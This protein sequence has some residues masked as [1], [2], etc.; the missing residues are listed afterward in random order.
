MRILSV[1]FLVFSE[2]LISSQDEVINNRR[3]PESFKF[4]VA[5][6]AFQIEGAWNEDGKGESMWDRFL[7]NNSSK[8]LDRRNADVACDSYHKWREDVQLLKELGVKI[9]R[10]SISWPRILPDGTTNK[11]NQAGVD[12][13]LN[14]L[15]EL[16]ANNIEPLVTLYHWDLPQHLSELGGWLN[17]QIVD[18]FGEFA[19]LSFRLFG[20]YVRQWTTVNEPKTACL[21]GYA[22]DY[23]APGLWLVADGVYQCAKIQLLAHAKAW[24]IYDDEFRASQG[25]KIGFVLDTPWNEPASDSDLDREAAER[26]MQFG[27]GWFANPVFIGDWP[28]VMKDRIANRSKLEGLGFS[29]LPEFTQKEIDYINGTHD[30][31]GLNIYTG[32]LVEY[33]P[34]YEIGTPN[35]NF[36]NG[37]NVYCD[38]SWPASSSDWLFYYPS[39]I[40]KL[41]NYVN[42]KYS[43]EE[44]FI[45]ENG[46]ADHGEIDDQSRIRYHKGYLSNLLDAILEDGVN[47]VGYTAWSF[48]DNFGWGA[49]YTHRFGFISV[50]HDSPNR[51]RT[52]KSSG[53]YYQKVIRT[54]CLVDTCVD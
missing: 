21:L 16:K 23:G 37:N 3:F 2:I 52:W 51:T 43:P 20:D 38:P 12:Y 31:I 36:D 54:R 48:M 4:G 15:K 5:T 42:E 47:V 1:T 50:D 17:P 32:K 7:H 40:R 27:F 26:E 25:G 41:V 30:Y 13:Y 18:Y 24:H 39:S 53:R 28:Q 9:Y 19:R 10:F 46:W 35:Y 8:T 34:D 6:S 33:L 45:A 14:L 11:I 49:G 44:I 22:N 29:R